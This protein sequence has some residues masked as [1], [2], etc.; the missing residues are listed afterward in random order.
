MLDGSPTNNT[1]AAVYGI[2]PVIPEKIDVQSLA[3]KVLTAASPS[4]NADKDAAV[5]VACVTY[6]ERVL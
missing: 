6:P 1:S 3:D 2:V 4:K 5:N